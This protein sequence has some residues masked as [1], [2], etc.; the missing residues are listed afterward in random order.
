M[1][2]FTTYLLF[3][4]AAYIHLHCYFSSHLATWLCHSQSLAGTMEAGG[5]PFLE[6]PGEVR[7]NIYRHLLLDDQPIYMP[8]DPKTTPVHV[9]RLCRQVFEEATPIF[10]GENAFHFLE[11]IVR[12]SRPWD[13]PFRF[14]QHVRKIN[15]RLRYGWPA[16]DI[17]LSLLSELQQFTRLEEIK[18]QLHKYWCSNQGE[19]KEVDDGLKQVL[20][21]W[22]TPLGKIM[23]AV[24]SVK[25]WLIEKQVDASKY[26]WVSCGSQG[27]RL[28]LDDVEDKD[29]SKC[30]RDTS[31]PSSSKSSEDAID[32]E[33]D[34]EED[35][36]DDDSD[37]FNTAVGEGRLHY[38]QRVVIH[39]AILDRDFEM[40]FNVMLV[41]SLVEEWIYAPATYLHFSGVPDW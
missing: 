39:Q 31:E 34:L 30:D 35:T 36:S 32:D 9:L 16:L 33:H 10:Y 27:E 2:V 38:R 7:N 5:F 37:V 21:S 15:I 41:P 13:C 3:K 11:Q 8:C 6:L 25:V 24:P 22:S 40:P 23:A 17:D 20:R 4:Y 18:I 19:I 29:K 14:R 28:T 1:L 26:Q 12:N